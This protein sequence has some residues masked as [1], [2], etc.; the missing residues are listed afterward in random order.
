MGKKR[1][2]IEASKKQTQRRK[3]PVESG[4]DPLG[5][6]IQLYQIHLG[7]LL[8]V[9]GVISLIGLGVMSLAWVWTAH[10]LPFLFGG[11]LVI[12]TAVGAFGMS[13]ANVGRSLELRKYGLRY[14]E[15]G[16]STEFL[17]DEII[18]VEVDRIDETY[19]GVA[20][21]RRRS[22][23]GYGLSGPLTK[24]EMRITLHSQDGRS[25]DLSPTFLKTVRDTRNLLSQLRLRSGI[26]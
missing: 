20:S 2:D 23:D 7:V 5:K 10:K 17:W 22:Q 4:D 11:G 1:G 18:D 24:T 14:T 9:F 26:R 25:I 21:V 6:I 8:V 19:L 16:T 12:L 13:V 3:K 15:G